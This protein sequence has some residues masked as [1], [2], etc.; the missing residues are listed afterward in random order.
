MTIKYETKIN[1]IGSSVKAFLGDKMLI[2]FGENA[3]AE[4][5][6]FC[7]SIT[8][9]EVEN[10]IEVGDTLQIGERKYKI[11][12]IGEAVEKN[13]SSLG[14]ITLNFDGSETPGLPGTLYLEE[15]EIYEVN[16]GDIIKVYA[17]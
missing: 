17:D 3:P 10:K 14:H 5:A 11:T 1:N 13:L 9:N 8:V 12:A 6:D 2:L 7:L 4:L 15:T 16:T